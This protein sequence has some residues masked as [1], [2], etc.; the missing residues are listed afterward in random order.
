MNP[1]TI[2]EAY[3]LLGARLTLHGR[4]D[5]WSVSVYG[6]NAT[7]EIYNVNFTYQPLDNAL[8]VRVP[9]TGATLVRNS[10]SDPRT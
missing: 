1:Q 3:T 8:G 2:Q 7:D 6:E 9:A 4:D 5:V 10:L